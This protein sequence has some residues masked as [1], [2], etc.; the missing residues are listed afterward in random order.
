MIQLGHVWQVTHIEAFSCS[1]S[2]VFMRLAPLTPSP[3]DVR[4]EPVLEVQFL[5]REES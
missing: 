5:G 1:N 2:W 4:N 3:W